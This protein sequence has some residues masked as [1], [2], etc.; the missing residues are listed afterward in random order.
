M[1]WIKTVVCDEWGEEASFCPQGL[2]SCS[3]ESDNEEKDDKEA[4]D[5]K[6]GKEDKDD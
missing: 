3:S 5:D 4:K 1:D 6:E 2:S